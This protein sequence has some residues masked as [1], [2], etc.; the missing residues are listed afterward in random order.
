MKLKLYSSVF[1][2]E[3]EHRLVGKSGIPMLRLETSV[4]RHPHQADSQ[5]AGCN[6]DASL[7]KPVLGER[8]P[9]ENALFSDPEPATRALRWNR[10]QLRSERFEE[11][12]P[13]LT[14]AQEDYARL[15]REVFE[16]ITTHFDKAPKT[17]F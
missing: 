14:F 1:K 9:F 13:L 12:E 15:D 6:L 17:H 8:V 3:S 4:V 10:V 11:E 2:G 7:I 16:N 5:S